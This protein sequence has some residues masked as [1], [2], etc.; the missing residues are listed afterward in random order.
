MEPFL[1]LC[2]QF[3]IL[4]STKVLI[5]S[6]IHVNGNHRIFGRLFQIGP[7]LAKFP[8]NPGTCK[9]IP[10]FRRVL[11]R[12]GCVNDRFYLEAKSHASYSPVWKL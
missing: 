11:G 9:I 12:F 5:T 4:N 1:P 8:R 2:E 7:I 10:L 3:Q 6:Y